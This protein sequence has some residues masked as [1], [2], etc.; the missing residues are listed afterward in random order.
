MA[1]NGTDVIALD[2]KRMQV[3][4]SRDFDALAALLAD[5][6]VYTHSNGKLDTKKSL[7]DA[8]KSGSTVY[9]SIEPS[10]VEAIDVGDVVILTGAAD[11]HVNSNHLRLRFTDVYANRNGAWQMVAWHSARLPD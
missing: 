2:K 3:T 10:G 1:G 6:M 5:D 9:Q 8:L 7:I 11:I 4:V